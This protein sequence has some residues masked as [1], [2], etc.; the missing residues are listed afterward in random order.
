[1]LSYENCRGGGTGEAS[2]ASMLAPLA[3]YEVHLHL[4][5]ISRVD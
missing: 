1:M 2:Q 5:R 3:S 4:H